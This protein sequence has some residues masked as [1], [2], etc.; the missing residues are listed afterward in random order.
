MLICTLFIYQDIQTQVTIFLSGTDINFKELLILCVHPQI[1]TL[2]TGTP[3]ILEVSQRHGYRKSHLLQA[4][5]YP[6]TTSKHVFPTVL[7]RSCIQLKCKCIFEAASCTLNS[8]KYSSIQL[9]LQLK[10]GW[11]D[12]K[13]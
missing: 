7:E 4:Q 6:A 11:L 10:F 9:V 1:F 2:S 8:T 5:K 12:C 3:L 13:G